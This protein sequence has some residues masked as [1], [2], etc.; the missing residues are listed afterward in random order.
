MGR[1]TRCSPQIRALAVARVARIRPDQRS[2]WQTMKIVA[3]ELGV[4]A[5]TLRGWVRQAEMARSQDH[6]WDHADL[7]ELRRLR[8]E[9]ARLWQV[10]DLTLREAGAVGMAHGATHQVSAGADGIGVGS[11]VGAVSEQAEPVLGDADRQ[12]LSPGEGDRVGFDAVAE[13]HKEFGL[14]S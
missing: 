5:E 7:T 1:P 10:L 9:N 2:G 3:A 11:L 6:R 4:S 13:V 14:G 12:S 8:E